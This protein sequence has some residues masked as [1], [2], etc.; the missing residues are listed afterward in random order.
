MSKKV[1]IIYYSWSGNTGNIARLIQHKTGGQLFEVN[2]VQDYPSDYGACVEQA[3]K[4]INSRFMPELK[5][6]PDNLDSYDVIFIGTP[7][8]WH[9]MAPP[10]FTFLSHTDLAGKTVV[11]FCTHGGSGKGHYINDVAK[12]C[13][14]SVVLDELVVY[15]NGGKSA[16][17]DVMAWLNRIGF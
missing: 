10:V 5:A 8:W 9:T 12:L 16:E 2:P 1:F 15:G 7:V 3:K 17:T 4:E 13:Q 14:N 11:P 6:I